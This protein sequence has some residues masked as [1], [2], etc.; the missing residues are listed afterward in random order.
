MHLSL[1]IDINRNY[2]S[3]RYFDIAHNLSIYLQQAIK[4]VKLIKI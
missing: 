4:L 2:V 3:L 1:Q